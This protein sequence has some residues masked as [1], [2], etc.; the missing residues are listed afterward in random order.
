MCTEH[1]YK[2]LYTFQGVPPKANNNVMFRGTSFACVD[3]SSVFV[4]EMWIWF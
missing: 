2:A 1:K 4:L 3:W